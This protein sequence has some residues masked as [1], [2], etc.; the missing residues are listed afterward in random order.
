MFL[1]GFIAVI[2]VGALKLYNMYSGHSYRL[3]TDSPY[4]YLALTSML[5]GT[6]LF[7]TGF[8]GELVIRHSNDRNHYEIGEETGDIGTQAI[9][10]GNH[11]NDLPQ[12]IIE[13]VKK[14]SIDEP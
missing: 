14:A 2:L 12:V 5:L 3:V 6:Q 10:P 11:D 7:L 4:F 1:L 9:A 13:P 8:L